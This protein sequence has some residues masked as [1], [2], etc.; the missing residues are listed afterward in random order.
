MAKLNITFPDGSKKQ[1]DAG[2]TP[3]DI[4]KSIGPRLAKDTLAAKVG[5]EL[6][7]VSFKIEKDCS[8][9]LIT[10]KDPE[11]KDIFRHSAAHI[12]A[13]AIQELFPKAKNT[14]GP[15]VEEGFYYDFGDLNITPEDFAKI[16]AKMKEIIKADLPCKRE[17][18]YR[19]MRS[20]RS[21][22]T[23]STRSRWP[24]SSRPRAASCLLTGSVTSL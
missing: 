13:Y 22:R 10:F 19:S 23:I 2:V 3:L 7:D 24:Q 14:I 12:F 15:A 20:R 11:G 16:E 18:N 1:F 8:I 21:S 6:V 4:A 9:R 17:S 5:D